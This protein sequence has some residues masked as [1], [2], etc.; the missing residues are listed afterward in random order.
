MS[1]MTTVQS[2]IMQQVGG[3]KFCVMTGVKTIIAQGDN[4]LT[5]TIGGG[6]K[7]RIKYFTVELQGDDTYKVMFRKIFKNELKTISEFSGIYCDQLQE[8]FTQETG[9]YTSL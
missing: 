7:K 4:G 2:A 8:I 5:F 3:N 6:A 1:N 9:M